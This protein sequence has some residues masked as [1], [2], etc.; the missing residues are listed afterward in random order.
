MKPLFTLL[1]A[2]VLTGLAGNPIQAG[3]TGILVNDTD[4]SVLVRAQVDPADAVPFSLAPVK[5]PSSSVESQGSPLHMGQS[6]KELVLAPGGAVI[7]S[8]AAPAGTTVTVP[9]II[10]GAGDQG[11]TFECEGT[12][13]CV[14][15]KLETNATLLMDSDEG[16][17]NEL[18][19]SIL[20]IDANHLRL[21]L[22]A[23]L[24][25]KRL[26]KVLEDVS[27]G[28]AGCCIVS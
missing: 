17:R 6:C 5:A 3:E 20:A 23:A 26:E 4:F 22:S 2:G 14:A 21:E 9:F 24:E 27:L 15:T 18:P 7:F 8:S 25:Q 13:R 10:S 28:E 1:L 19:I 11:P 12:F 16:N